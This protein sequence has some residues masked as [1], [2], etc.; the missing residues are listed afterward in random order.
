MAGFA[1]LVVLSLPH[2]VVFE[3]LL[4]AHWVWCAVKFMFGKVLEKQYAFKQ[5]FLAQYFLK[6]KLWHCP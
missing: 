3:C 5:P 2:L 1:Q 4:S 6:A